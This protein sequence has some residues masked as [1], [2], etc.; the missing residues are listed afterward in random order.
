MIVNSLRQRGW[1]SRVN[2]IQM[3]LEHM[4]TGRLRLEQPATRMDREN[5]SSRED[6]PP[7]KNG[8]ARWHSVLANWV[9]CR[10][11]HS[12]T[13]PHIHFMPLTLAERTPLPAGEEGAGWTLE[14]LRLKGAF[15]D[16]DRLRAFLAGEEEEEEEPWHSENTQTQFPFTDE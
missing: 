15:F 3:I 13:Y 8:L 6:M 9:L 14:L 12:C 11:T 16:F 7:P 2:N 10:I 4:Q 5:T 1:V